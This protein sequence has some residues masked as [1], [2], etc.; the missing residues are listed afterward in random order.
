M[1]ITLFRV[2]GIPIR[3]HASFVLLALALVLFRWYDQGPRAAGAGAVLGVLLFGSVLLHE[4][5]HARMG[6]AFGVPTRDVT[7]YP[8]GGVASM[9][10]PVGDSRAELW[11]A[12]AGPLVN[13]LL[14]ALGLGMVW[15]EVPA[16]LPF[17][18]VNAGMAVFNLIP[19]Y[20]MDGGRILRAFWSRKLG[21]V[22]AT[23]RAIRLSRFLAWGFLL[24]S[25]TGAPSLA[26][27]GGFLL[28]ATGAERR[29]WEIL[30]RQA[31]LARRWRPA[32]LW[33]PAGG[34]FGWRQGMGL[35]HPIP[36][37]EPPVSSR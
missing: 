33:L 13:V 6:M 25:L 19:A 30:A 4:L 17:A 2:W 12:L 28:L 35:D 1:S 15:A 36:Q 23:L 21:L 11:I 14:F 26:L 18:A 37:E 22:A 34:P 32:P 8:F 10:L 16:A 31:E 27:A 9:R 20:P 29:R 7:L 5:G 3:L 24:V